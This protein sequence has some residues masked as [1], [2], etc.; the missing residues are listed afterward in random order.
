MKTIAFALTGI[1]F[2]AVP[3]HF[4]STHLSA[5][6]TDTP[7]AIELSYAEPETWHNLPAYILNQPASQPPTA[8]TLTGSRLIDM[9]VE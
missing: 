4:E 3:Q 9:V 7:A 6:V 1:A 2:C 8:A 5:A